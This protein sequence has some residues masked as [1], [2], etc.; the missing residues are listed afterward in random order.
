MATDIHFAAQDGKMRYLINDNWLDVRISIVPITY[1]EN[2]VM[3]LLYPKNK[4]LG[5][6]DLGLSDDNLKKIKK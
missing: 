2:I 5:L 3:R 4:Q 6:I 1:G